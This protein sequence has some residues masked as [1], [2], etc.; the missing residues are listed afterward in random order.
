M[1]LSSFTHS[2]YPQHQICFIHNIFQHLTFPPLTWRAP[3]QTICAEFAILRMLSRAAEGK[4]T[5]RCVYVAPVDVAAQQRYAE[6]KVKFGEGLG[7]N[8]VLLTGKLV[9]CE[10]AGIMNMCVRSMCCCYVAVPSHAPLA[11]LSCKSY[12]HELSTSPL[13]KTME[14]S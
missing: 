5:P 9:L 1:Q 2:G 6:W 4:V 3:S 10:C 8:V 11:L 12:T 13:L 7:I 14:P